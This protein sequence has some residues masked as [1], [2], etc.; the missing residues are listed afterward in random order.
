MKIRTGSDLNGLSGSE[1]IRTIDTPGM[2]TRGNLWTLIENKIEDACAQNHLEVSRE[3]MR[4]IYM[5][6]R[7]TMEQRMI[8]RHGWCLG[9]L[10]ILMI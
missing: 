10:I 8:S 2:N 1:R 3:S 7:S 5:E 9:L 4:W 6:A